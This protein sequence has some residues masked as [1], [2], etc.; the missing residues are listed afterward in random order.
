MDLVLKKNG[1]F[2][3]SKI[4]ASVYIDHVIVLTN[5]LTFSDSFSRKHENVFWINR[6][7]NTFS[8]RKYVQVSHW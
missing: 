3:K 8:L 6:T 7:Q 2:I 4:N 5:Q 1:K